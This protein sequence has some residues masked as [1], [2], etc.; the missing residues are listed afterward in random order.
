MIALF[1]VLV[2]ECQEHGRAPLISVS[3]TAN[4]IRQMSHPSNNQSR[5]KA[6]IKRHTVPNAEANAITN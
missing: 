6:H 4:A 1:E 5:K 3:A 2:T